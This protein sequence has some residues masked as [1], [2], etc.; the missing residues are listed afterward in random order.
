M[1]TPMMISCQRNV[2]LGDPG[3][4]VIDHGWIHFSQ[5]SKSTAVDLDRKTTHNFI[6]VLNAASNKLNSIHM[7]V[8]WWSLK[9]Q[10]LGNK[11]KMCCR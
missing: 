2:I 4:A 9:P 6:L 11:P 5:Y 10:S 7:V 8:L 1:F 3:E